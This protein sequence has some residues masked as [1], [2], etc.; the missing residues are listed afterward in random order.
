MFH[1]WATVIALSMTPALI[2]GQ[3]GA[4]AA[5]IG[6]GL[7][8]WIAVPVIAMSGFVEGMLVAWLANASTRIGF[9]NRWCERMRKPKAVAFARKW[10]PWGGMTLGVAAVG[11]EPILIALRWL[12]VDV[13]KLILP[14]LISNAVFAV[15]YYAIVWFGFDLL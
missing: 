13:R 6:F 12:G 4:A 10:G 11:Q 5:A 3:S 9:V 14:T 15:L 7:D 8:P 1:Q 2:M